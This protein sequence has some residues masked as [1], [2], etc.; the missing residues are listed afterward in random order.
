MQK[1][2]FYL[3]FFLLTITSSY[4]QDSAIEK[5]LDGIFARQFKPNEPGCAVLIAKQGRVIYKKAFGSADLELNTEITPDM[6]FKLASITKQF[7]AVAI[8]QLV[9]K[10]K[11][12]LQDSLQK[13]IPDFPSKGKTITIENLL[14]HT[15]GIRDYMQIDYAHSFMERWDFKPKQLIDSFKNY[16]LEF[17]PGTRF[18]YSNSGYYLLGYIIEMI[19]GKSYQTYIRDNLLTPL[20]LT[21]THFDSAGIIIPGRLHGYRKEGTNFKNADY[22]SPTIAY[23]AGGLLSNT[24]DLFNWFQGLLDD[25]ILKKETLVKAFT[26]FALKDGSPTTYG[27]GWYIHDL[28][29]VQSIEHSGKMSGFLS[30]EVYYPQQDVFIAALFNTQ[31]APR[32]EITKD[33]SEIVLGQKLQIEVSK[34]TDAVSRS[35]IGTYS[36]T[37]NPGRTITVSKEGNR[38]LLKPSGQQT[39]EILFQSDTKFQIKNV[40]DLTG[41]FISERGRVTKIIINQNGRFEWEKIK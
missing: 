8:L 2:F 15:S 1:P 37:I 30:N 16:A 29:A 17:D 13:F 26:R 11:I 41:E 39:M 33:I 32:D 12:S 38:F 24:G 36:L 10:G 25:K 34:P 27:Y 6:V 14:T 22:W 5:Q 3:S 19:S 18:S 7:T 28:G 9:E 31:D 35:Y 4:G 23:S 20:A 21:Y 40:K